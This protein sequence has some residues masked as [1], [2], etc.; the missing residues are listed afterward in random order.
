[1]ISRITPRLVELTYEATLKSFHRRK[2]L[3]TFLLTSSIP[4]AFISTWDQSET[5]REFLDR[6]FPKLCAN[7]NGKIV[8]FKIAKS[9]SEKLTFPDMLGFEDSEQKIRE[10]TKATQD[11]KGYLANQESSI[12]TDQERKKTQERVHEFKQNIQRSITDRDQLQNQLKSINSMIGTQE[13]GYKFEEW[14]FQ[15]LEYSDINCRRPYKSNG[16]QIDGSLTIDGTTYLLEL[17]FTQKQSTANDIDS[18]KAK[19]DKMADNTMGIMISISSYS[20]V[21]I[22]DASGR[23]T[24]LLLI[25]A[26]HL[27]LFLS[28]AMNFDEILTRIRRHASQTGEAYLS[29]RDFYN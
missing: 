27:Y 9:L 25:D 15:L 3:S 8:I 14:F 29:I 10:A 18:L 11:L 2:A 19:V 13:G 5:K 28:G 24:T 17:K 23:K 7:D 22:S 16:R 21:A 12:Q 20:S 6:L 1:M 4:E 26:S